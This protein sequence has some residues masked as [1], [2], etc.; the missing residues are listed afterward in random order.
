MTYVNFIRVSYHITSYRIVLLIIWCN[1]GRIHTRRIVSHAWLYVKLC[2]YGEE[3]L[4]PDTIHV[5]FDGHAGQSFGFTLAKGVF[6]EVTYA[7]LKIP[8]AR[9]AISGMMC[10]SDILAL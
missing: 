10:I 1:D 8:N 5:K 7:I 3:G 2:R 4:P 6:L 9:P